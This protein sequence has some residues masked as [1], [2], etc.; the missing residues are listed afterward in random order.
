MCTKKLIFIKGD[1]TRPK[2]ENL[3]DSATL[4]ESIFADIYTRAFRLIDE[5]ANQP[6]DNNEPH[7]RERNN[8]VAFIGERGSGKTSCLR[9][10]YKALPKHTFDNNNTNKI[11]YNVKLPIIDPSYLD[12]KS[13]ILEI[14]IAHMFKLFKKN[15][16]ENSHNLREDRLEKKRQLVK[17]FQDVKDALDCLNTNIKEDKYHNDSI[18]ELSKLAAGSNL[19]EK[20]EKLVKSYLD[21]FHGDSHG[22]KKMLVIAID[23]LDVQT[24][25]TYSMVEQIR[26]YLIIDNVIIL[27]GVKLVQLSGLIKKKYSK[28]FKI[29]DQNDQIDDMVARYLMKLLPLSHR[30]NLPSYN[31]IPNVRLVVSDSQQDSTNK[32]PDTNENEAN[33]KKTEYKSA[34]PEGVNIQETI[35]FLIYHKTNFMFYNSLEQESL[36]IP[37]NLRELLNLVALLHNMSDDKKESNLN[38]FRQYFIESWCLDRLTSKQHNFIKEMNECDSI[39][40]NKFIVD[41]INSEFNKDKQRISFDDSVV[42]SSNKSYNVS[43]ADVN[44]VLDKLYSSNRASSKWLVFAIKTVYSMRLYDKFYDL[45]D[46]NTISNNAELLYSNLINGKKS[47]RSTN[48]LNHIFDYEKMLGGNV[49]N[50]LKEDQ[51]DSCLLYTDT[52]EAAKMKALLDKIK[53]T[54]NKSDIVNVF[55]V[56]ELLLLSTT[57]YGSPNKARQ[58]KHCYYNSFPIS[59]YPSDGI[60]TINFTAILFNIIRYYALYKKHCYFREHNKYDII[61]LQRSQSNNKSQPDSENEKCDPNTNPNG[62]HDKTANE[63]D[64]TDLQTFRDFFELIEN[65]ELNAASII[66]QIVTHLKLSDKGQAEDINIFNIA[67]LNLEIL[68]L[69]EDYLG[70]INKKQ[71]KDTDNNI[72]DLKSFFKKLSLFKSYIY[73]ISKNENKPEQVAYQEF[74][75]K[76]LE[77]IYNAFEDITKNNHD[78]FVHNYISAHKS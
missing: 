28:D 64:T 47:Y 13:N 15:V 74:S 73:T 37:H 59:D 38:I 12:D 9:S 20:M 22:K 45:L 6:P 50:I 32:N 24:N 43:I 54:E 18:E 61:N 8:I 51:D 57:Y 5:I 70:Y 26:K 65:K 40:I 39:R 31:E 36:I 58:F 33:N 72:R 42:N 30:L 44:Y 4:N 63:T 7:S 66:Y 76:H 34:I 11:I 19:H 23:D 60:V 35:L 53:S 27:I 52:I 3:N 46:E 62:E 16:T 21:F 77:K 75:M 71:Q 14:V 29:Q 55:K 25:H 67:I 41:Y 10:V 68:E 69:I 49:V 17:R 56:F 1:E 48:K 78:L 2:I